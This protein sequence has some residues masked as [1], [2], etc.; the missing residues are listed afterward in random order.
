MIPHMFRFIA[1]R[2][3]YTLWLQGVIISTKVP[4]VTTSPPLGI[5]AVRKL[6]RLYPS[7]SRYRRQ[8]FR[9]RVSVVLQDMSLEW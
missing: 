7:R 9:S 2:V 6:L 4:S 8:R 5:C 3:T 1:G